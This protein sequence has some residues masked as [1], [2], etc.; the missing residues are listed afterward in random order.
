MRYFLT[1][2]GTLVVSMIVF[3][4]IRNTHNAQYAE[5]EFALS[6]TARW[7]GVIVA[8]IAAAKFLVDSLTASRLTALPPTLVLFLV[9]ML[10]YTQSWGVALALGAIGVVLAWKGNYDVPEKRERRDL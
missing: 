8:I 4:S 10:L 7:L 1:I 6:W 2:V 9:G 5:I 3:V